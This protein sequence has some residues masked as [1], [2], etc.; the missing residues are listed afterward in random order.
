MTVH[1]LF[2][3]VSS[4]AEAAAASFPPLSGALSAVAAATGPAGVSLG[5]VVTGIKSII[6]IGKT[7]YD[8]VQ[9]IVAGVK[10]AKVE[11]YQGL[12]QAMGSVKEL[13]A[14]YS[15]QREQVAG[16]VVAWQKAML[17]MQAAARGLRMTQMDGIISQLKGAKD[18]AVAQAN[19]NKHMRAGR[20]ELDENRSAWRGFYTDLQY[21]TKEAGKE[22]VDT[23]VEAGAY[24]GMTQEQIADSIAQSQE[25]YLAW[26]REREALEI[27][28]E[29]ARAQQR[30][31]ELQA[32]QANLEAAYKYAS[33][34]MSMESVTRQLESAAKNL[35][36]MSGKAFGFDQAGAMVGQ[37]VA[38]LLTEKA[39]IEAEQSANRLKLFSW[40]ASG[41]NRAANTRKAQ[42]DSELQRLYAMPEW[43][44]WSPEQQA[45]INAVMSQA[46]RLGALGGSASIDRLIK[47]SAIGDPGRAMADIQLRTELQ[48]LKDQQAA[49]NEQMRKA[50][51][52]AAYPVS[53][54]H[55]TLLT[56]CSV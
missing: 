10:Q 54:T 48:G 56:I 51:L 45:S 29:G 15:K 30:V 47:T 35:A 11:V 26:M 31:L 50:A 34:V 3:Q 6:E 1:D 41:A 19:L 33:A 37:R 2:P 21:G 32:Q 24:V 17:D 25:E 14:L 55:L 20:K 53:Y 43:E 49:M 4:M 28:I 38:D 40:H 7:L 44:G 39:Q 5:V 16:L 42:I 36:I 22:V 8:I 46:R 18:V 27:E 13:N 52:D 12:S 23:W 9:R